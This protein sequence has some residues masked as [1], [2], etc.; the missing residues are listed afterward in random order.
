MK[1]T[2]LFMVLI[3]VI[4]IAVSVCFYALGSKFYAG[5]FVFMGTLFSVLLFGQGLTKED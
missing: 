1:T 5:Y 2:N 3:P 4:F